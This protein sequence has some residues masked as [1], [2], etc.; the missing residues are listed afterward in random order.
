MYKIA[1][2]SD[3]M[4]SR[5]IPENGQNGEWQSSCTAEQG[6]LSWR[7]LSRCSW[8]VAGEDRNRRPVP[9]MDQAAG[10]GAP[11]VEP[12]GERETLRVNAA[13][14]RLGRAQASTAFVCF[15]RIMPGTRTFL[16]LRLIRTQMP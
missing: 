2:G 14:F 6:C 5:S 4:L 1:Q 15:P 8:R 7:L 11:E 10:Q 13:V 3:L 12:A 9:T 16:R